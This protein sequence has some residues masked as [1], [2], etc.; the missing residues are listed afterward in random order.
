MPTRLQIMELLRGG[1]LLDAV[2]EKGHYR[3][4]SGMVERSCKQAVAHPSLQPACREE[5][6]RTIFVQLIRGIQY[7]HNM[8]RLEA[9]CR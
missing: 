8:A 9:L 7:L 3:R 5:D 4:V 2:V 6:A 1:E